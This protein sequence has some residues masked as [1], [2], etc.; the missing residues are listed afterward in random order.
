MVIVM[1]G[2]GSCDVV[3]IAVTTY[4]GGCGGDGDDGGNGWHSFAENKIISSR[5]GITKT[6][7]SIKI[8]SAAGVV[9]PLAPSAI[10]WKTSILNFKK[11]I[12]VV[13]Y[14]WFSRIRQYGFLKVSRAFKLFKTL[15]VLALSDKVL[16]LVF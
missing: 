11:E 6:F 15:A 8:L 2:D 16:L 3:V 13:F 12:T 10:T 5:T 14:I 1:T 9:G 7:L 4:D